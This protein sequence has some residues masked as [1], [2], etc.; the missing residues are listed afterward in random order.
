M[1]KSMF[2][3]NE[4]KTDP[5]MTRFE[6]LNDWQNVFLNSGIHTNDILIKTCV[7]VIAK[8]VAKLHAN[9]IM[10]DGKQKKPVEDSA[11]TEMLTLEP[12]PYMTAY[13][14]LYRTAATA[15]TRGNAYIQIKRDKAGRPA[16]LWAVDYTTVE[17]MEKDDE[18]YMRFLFSNGKQATIPYADL[19]HVRNFF[20]KG[21]VV[22]EVDSNLESVLALLETLQ[23]SFENAAVNSGHI[24][25]VAQISGQIGTDVWK[26]KSQMLMEQIRDKNTGG[27]V[28]TDG[29]MSF[30]PN[31]QEPVAADHSQL[32]YLRENVYRY[33]GV[34]KEIIANNYTE[35]QW[36]AFFESTIEPFAIRLSQEFTRKLFT[37]KERQDGNQIVFDANRLTYATTATKTEMIR[38]LRPLGILTTNQ[39]LEIMNLPPVKDGDDRLVQTL[40]LVNTQLVDDYQKAK[41]GKEVTED[42]EESGNEE[43]GG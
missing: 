9:H 4:E 39:S 17:L 43:N 16:S 14:L 3:K 31:N 29:T 11:L 10:R 23:Q 18:L 42:D 1:F 12:N 7:D 19:I 24:K 20:Q 32:D 34:S 13:D 25:G 37:K 22:S 28:T 21:E 6:M 36:Q 38:Q 15:M 8:H 2:G 5:S 35:S 26:K 30:T 41:A 33:F 27:I 40:N